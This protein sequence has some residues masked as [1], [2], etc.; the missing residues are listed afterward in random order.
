L[1]IAVD[2]SGAQA[3]MSRLPISAFCVVAA[4]IRPHDPHEA[5]AVAALVPSYATPGT[6]SAHVNGVVDVG[7]AYR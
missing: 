1:H 7:R 5:A 3:F 4:N 6:L 2:M